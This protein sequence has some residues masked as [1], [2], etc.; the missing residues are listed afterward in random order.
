MTEI[1]PGT[2]GHRPLGVPPSGTQQIDAG[3]L[4][5]QPSGT[6]GF[7]YKPL[8]EDPASALRTWLMRIEPGASAPMHAHT[9][10]EQI[11][12]LEG[13]FYDQNGVYTPGDY[14]VRAP[15]AEHTAGSEDG[16]TV[17]LIYSRA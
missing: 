5:W 15:G 2:A 4:A 6:E 14:L 13:T 12:V 3:T 7:L 17:L 16:A 1:F 11:Y 10:A 8:F 9:E